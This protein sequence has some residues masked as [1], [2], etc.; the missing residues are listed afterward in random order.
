MKWLKYPD[1]MP[2]PAILYWIRFRYDA[3]GEP[4]DYTYGAGQYNPMSR[5]WQSDDWKSVEFGL[6]MEVTHFAV[7]E[8]PES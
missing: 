2:E 4:E 5:A 7:I 3:V 8:E 1:N 6:S